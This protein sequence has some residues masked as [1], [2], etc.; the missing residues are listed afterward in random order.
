M[1]GEDVS[2]LVTYPA[3]K[4]LFEVKENSKQLSEKKGELFPLV[5]Y[6][7]LFSMKR[8]RP[9][10]DTAVGFLTTR[11]SK[12]DIGDWEKLRWILRF[13]HFT[14]REKDILEQQV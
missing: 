8:S 1:F 2:T 14:H 5:V 3:T 13:V 9:D 11:V 4:K 10:L 12:S 6:K 7:L